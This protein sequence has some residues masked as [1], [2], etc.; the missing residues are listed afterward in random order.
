MISV[1]MPTYNEAGNVKELILRVE[2]VLKK[3]FEIIVVDDASIDGTGKYVSDLKRKKPFLRL[4]KRNER[5]LASAVKR[6][7]EEARGNIVSWFDCDLGMPPEKLPQMIKLL[8]KND[9]VI[10][11]TFIFGGEDKREV[12]HAQL[13]SR[14][15]NLL[16]KVTLGG[17]ISDYTSGFIVAKKRAVS[18]SNFEGIH[19]AYFISMLYQ[20]RRNGYRIIE[21]PYTLSPR[22]YG[23]SKIASPLSYLKAGLSY[24]K[25]LINSKLS[26]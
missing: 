3:D 15:F 8:G 7:I 23:K 6:G 5:G 13:F 1:I 2:R 14:L 20:A 17:G 12:W 21:I 4:I 11:S 9:I 18:A 26:Q 19:G 16:A 10:G 25:V 22:F 24:L